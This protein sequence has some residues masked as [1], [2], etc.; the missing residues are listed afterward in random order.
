MF[1]LGI[2]IMLPRSRVDHLYR[3]K[4]VFH[5]YIVFVIKI[6]HKFLAVFAI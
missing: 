6:K 1:S 5:S 3:D 4:T 2:S